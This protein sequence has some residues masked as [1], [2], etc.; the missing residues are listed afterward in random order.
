MQQRAI[1]DS[2]Y[3]SPRQVEKKHLE[4]QKSIWQFQSDVAPVEQ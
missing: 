4:R 2:G 1:F 3:T